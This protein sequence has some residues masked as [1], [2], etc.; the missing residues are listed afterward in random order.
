MVRIQETELLAA[1]PV[2]IVALTKRAGKG[3]APAVST[4][5]P[6][7]VQSPEWTVRW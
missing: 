4:A 3:G 5:S 7:V 1:V 2:D 6:S